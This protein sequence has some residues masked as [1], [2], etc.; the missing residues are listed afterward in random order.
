MDQPGID[1]DSHRHAL[2]GLRRINRFSATARQIAAPIAAMA[3]RNGLKKLRIA[4]I[5][6]GGGDVPVAVAHR[7]GQQGIDVE[8]LLVDRSD[9]ALAQA[10]TT[11]AESRVAC[12]T[13]QT[14]VLAK[15]FPKTSIETSIE[16]SI[17]T[18]DVVTNS[19]FLHHIADTDAVIALLRVMAASASRMVV[20]SDLVRSWQGYVGAWIGCRLLSRSSVVHY[21]GPVSVRAAWT[22]AEMRD[23]AA[24]AGM[25][26]ARVEKSF[27]NRT[28]LIWERK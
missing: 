27:P 1:P 8:L 20:V 22:I 17:E 15:N 13:I 14:D 19:L 11:A 26:G 28:L 2:A 7:L 24:A 5:A 23:F 10:A 25:T 21:D 16:A 3:R 9:T 4:D 6:C 12:R 18:S